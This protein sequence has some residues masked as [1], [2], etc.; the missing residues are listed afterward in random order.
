MYPRMT[1]DVTF[2]IELPSEDALFLNYL[3]VPYPDINEDDVR[4]LGVHLENFATSVEEPHSAMPLPVPST[5][6]FMTP[7]AMYRGCHRVRRPHYRYT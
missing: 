3:A 4:Q 2:A 6:L 7:P 1:R 5:E